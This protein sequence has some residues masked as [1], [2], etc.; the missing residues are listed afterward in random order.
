MGR[1]LKLNLSNEYLKNYFQK[2][3]TLIID[4]NINKKILELAKKIKKINK[5]KVI[6]LGNGGSAA[7]ASHVSVDLTK[8]SGIRSI[9]FN[10]SDLLTCFSNDFGYEKWCAKA[11]E[12]Y[13][14]DKDIVILISSS[15]NSNNIV[16]AAKFCIKKNIF[17]TTFTGFNGKNKLSKLG[18]I[19][20]SVNSKN[21]NHIEMTH[22][23]W[24]LA[25]VDILINEKF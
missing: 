21:Y 8:T 9:N 5:N 17:F 23:I 20:F 6:I 22:H 19:N 16:N 4:E 11:L 24:L 12:Y 2:F 1:L 13:S 25:I 7:M 3:S 10:E 18:N 15:G 14:D